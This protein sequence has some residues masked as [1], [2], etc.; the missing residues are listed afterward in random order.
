MNLPQKVLYICERLPHNVRSG[1]DLRVQNQILALTEF[2]DVAV[3]GL[4]DSGPSIS[5]KI[6]LWESGKLDSTNYQKKLIE[7]AFQ[8]FSLGINPYQI[9]YDQNI[10]I[11]ISEAIRNFDPEV[12]I[13]SQIHALIYFDKMNVKTNIKVILDLGES[14][15]SQIVNLKPLSDH[16]LHRITFNKWYEKLK[17]YENK[18]LRIMDQVWLSS[19]IEINSILK[20][21]SSLKNL[22]LVQNSIFV[23]NYEN[24]SR[25]INPR[26]IVFTANFA[27]GPNINAVNFIMETIAK[28][29]SDFDFYFAGSNIPIWVKSTEL[30]NVYVSE[31]VDVMSEFL[32]DAFVSIVPLKE[33]CGTRLKILEA[34]ASGVPVISTEVGAAGIKAIPGRH[35]IQANESEHFVDAFRIL[36]QNPDVYANISDSA[37]KFVQKNYSISKLAQD[38]QFLISSPM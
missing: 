1:Q 7:S 17:N 16:L 6:K 13:F 23:Q 26:K 14:A 21:N 2:C 28:P 35:Y 36:Q 8:N 30:Q 12:I 38:L 32:S 19:D 25:K 9:L 18:I 20:N 15:H 10:A 27:Y 3:I 4:S 24:I 34:F 29:A 33:G 22:N 5:S 31:N 11:L 37:F